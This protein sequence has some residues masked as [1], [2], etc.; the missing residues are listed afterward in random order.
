MLVRFTTRQLI[1]CSFSWSLPQSL[2]TVPFLRHCPWLHYL[3][4]SLPLA[5]PFT[6]EFAPGTH[7]QEL[8]LNHPLR[9]LEN[10]SQIDQSDRFFALQTAPNTFQ[11]PAPDSFSCPSLDFLPLGFWWNVLTAFHLHPLFAI[12]THIF[13]LDI[14]VVH[15]QSGQFTQTANVQVDQ[16]QLR[17]FNCKHK[18]CHD[19][20]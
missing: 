11:G 3:H 16:F 13:E 9:P 19:K 1:W 7:F 15:H 8:P 20:S 6:S 17:H 2:A 18:Y 12:E 14:G 5:T 4:L 10:C